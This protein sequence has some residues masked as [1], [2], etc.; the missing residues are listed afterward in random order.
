[1]KHDEQYEIMKRMIGQFFT[2]WGI[3]TLGKALLLFMNQPS[4]EVNTTLD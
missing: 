1:M 4:N 2:A 3:R